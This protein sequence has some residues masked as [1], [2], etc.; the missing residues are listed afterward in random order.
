MKFF[1][2]TDE[3]GENILELLAHDLT[4]V[5]Q[6]LGKLRDVDN[7][8][9]RDLREV[10]AN[11]LTVEDFASLYKF[12]SY[13]TDKEALLFNVT[14]DGAEAF[15]SAYEHTISD[16]RAAL[17]VLIPDDIVHRAKNNI[18]AFALMFTP[19][20]D[21]IYFSDLARGKKITVVSPN[22]QNKPDIVSSLREL[23]VDKLPQF[24]RV[25]IDDPSVSAEL[26]FKRASELLVNGG[27]LYYVAD[28]S[29]N[30]ELLDYAMK[31][32]FTPGS[33]VED[34]IFKFV[35][36]PSDSKTIELDGD[37]EILGKFN[38]MKDKG[39]PVIGQLILWYGHAKPSLEFMGETYY[40]DNRTESRPDILVKTRRYISPDY[41][42]SFN[43]V[44][45]VSRMD[46]PPLYQMDLQIGSELTLVSDG[47]IYYLLPKHWCGNRKT[48]KKYMH[49]DYIKFLQYASS[50]GLHGK[51]VEKIVSGNY[52]FVYSFFHI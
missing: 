22:K 36:L 10:I 39:Q 24:T 11:N 38:K 5:F 48:D 1:Y 33:K 47:T 30:D 26:A 51:E 43:A 12:E 52:E 4:S 41:L 44:W 45:D 32:R 31:Y 50:L 46:S 3:E 21:K 23:P 28:K 9:I 37:R 49:P 2:I 13:E 8:I 15:S 27:Y 16:I 17:P 14:P 19:K 29:A 6:T 42:P 7:L 35:Y 18:P 40:V 25:V 34:N 20:E